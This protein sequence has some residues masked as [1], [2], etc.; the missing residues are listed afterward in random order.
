[1]LLANVVLKFVPVIVTVIPSAP[2]VGVKLVI[3]GALVDV[4]VIVKSLDD[5]TV[6]LFTVTAILPVVALVGTVTVSCVSVAAVTVAVIPLK[7]TVLAEVDVLK[8]VPVIITV[9]PTTPLAGVKL[10]MVGDVVASSSSLQAE[11]VNRH[12]A[13]TAVPITMAVNV[14]MD[15][16]IFSIII[17]LT[18]FKVDL[19][20]RLL[21]QLCIHPKRAQ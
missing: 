1:V 4:V 5:V 17:S 11:T 9:V 21:L 10:V 14:R 20:Q 13:I 2:L 18:Y 8:L 6:T 19:Q 16:F 7:V 12:T 15:T 3:V